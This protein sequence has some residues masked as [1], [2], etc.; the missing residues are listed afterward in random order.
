[1]LP[2]TQISDK[3]NLSSP[4][5]TFAGNNSAF[6]APKSDQKS[7]PMLGL[8]R[9]FEDRKAFAVAEA[10]KKIKADQIARVESSQ[11]SDAIKRTLAQIQRILAKK[12][13][14]IQKPSIKI[15]VDRR[16]SPIASKL[17]LLQGTL[18]Q[19]RIC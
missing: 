8:K 19:K 17:M 18:G 12:K 9:S 4:L 15:P 11:K 5:V 13:P 7:S 6:T 1:M 3:S 2:H 16:P 14:V 10:V